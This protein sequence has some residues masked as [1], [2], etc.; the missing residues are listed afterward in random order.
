MGGCGLNWYWWSSQLPVPFFSSVS[1][2][3][4][5]NSWW[6]CPPLSL[7]VSFDL[8]CSIA[9]SVR[10]CLRNFCGCVHLFGPLS[11]F[12]S[13]YLSPSMVALSFALFA[14]VCLI[15]LVWQDWG[16]V[17]ILLWPW[18][19]PSICSYSSP[20]LFVTYGPLA[21]ACLVGR[22]R[23]FW[24]WSICLPNSVLACLLVVAWFWVGW[25]G[26]LWLLYRYAGITCLFTVTCFLVV[27]VTRIVVVTCL[28]VSLLPMTMTIM[29]SKL[30][31]CVWGL[32]W[33]NLSKLLQAVQLSC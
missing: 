10:L 17:S 18:Q 14:F 22:V 11:L 12:L 8:L 30:A 20:A 9:G 6:L 24:L 2:R 28:F 21:L 26:G 27:V 4:S 16:V 5:P 1:L 7:F 29:F 33:C 19:L 23:G 31:H 25:D 15:A 32:R 13:F 3:L